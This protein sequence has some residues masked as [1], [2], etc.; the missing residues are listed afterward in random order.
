MNKLRKVSGKQLTPAVTSQQHDFGRQQ[1]ERS[2]AEALELIA[3]WPLIQ[4]RI[5]FSCGEEPHVV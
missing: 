3:A 2:R 1:Y 4:R 5:K